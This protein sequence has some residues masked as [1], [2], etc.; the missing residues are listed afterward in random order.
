M[1]KIRNGGRVSRREVKIDEVN[2]ENYDK[3]LETREAV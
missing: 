3:L 2:L 1:G